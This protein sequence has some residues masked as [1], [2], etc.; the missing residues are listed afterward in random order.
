MTE[1]EDL[2]EAHIR[3]IDSL[4]CTREGAVMADVAAEMRQRYEYFFGISDD[5]AMGTI[6]QSPCLTSKICAVCSRGQC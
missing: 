1:I 5:V 4:G 6:A 3:L 2:L